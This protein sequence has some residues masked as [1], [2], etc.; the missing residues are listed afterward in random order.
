[1]ETD[2]VEAPD[3]AAIAAAVAVVQELC[4]ADISAALVVELAIV[5]LD[6]VPGLLIFRLSP[7]GFVSLSLFVQFVGLV[8]LVGGGFD[9]GWCGSCCPCSKCHTPG[10]SKRALGDTG[11]RWRRAA[12]LGCSNTWAGTFVGAL[13]KG[14]QSC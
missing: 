7:L 13:S 6:P 3:D 14:W 9:V 2:S 11:C 8:G 1:M 5:G 4:A 12:G 10:R